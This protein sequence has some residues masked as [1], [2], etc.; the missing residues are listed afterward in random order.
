MPVGKE[1]I[2]K[3]EAVKGALLE[4]N[5]AQHAHMGARLLPNP[6]TLKSKMSTSR[7]RWACPRARSGSAK[8]RR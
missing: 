4:D 1:W 3:S 2:R 6:Y 8:A 5:H 7:R